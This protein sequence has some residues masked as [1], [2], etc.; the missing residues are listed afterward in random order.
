MPY[1]SVFLDSLDNIDNS[2]NELLSSDIISELGRIE[3]K[4][5]ESKK[6]FTPGSDKVLK[7][8]K[9]NLADVKVIILG[10]DPYPQ[11]GVATGRAFEVG[12]LKSW[13]DKFS[14]VSLKNIV[15]AIF[16]AYNPE[17]LKYSE[18]K[19]KIGEPFPLKAPFEIFTE[20]EK[21]GV[22]L[23]NTSFT[24]EIDKSNSHENYWKPFTISLLEYIAAKNPRI[25]WFLWGNNAK[26]ITKDTHIKN[27]IES[28]H[29]MM[30]YNKPGRDDD[31]LFGKI[32]AFKETKHLINWLG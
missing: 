23:L 19:N 9:V 10:Q 16:N 30:C 25:I 17:F 27:K 11:K 29:P 8:L 1:N 4:I 21:Q 18:I 5:F 3:E 32:N 12:T 20:W 13:R 14:N 22:L 15:R 26:S 7:F 6:E 31:F 2:W 28:M 24:C